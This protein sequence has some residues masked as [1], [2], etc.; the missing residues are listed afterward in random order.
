MTNIQNDLDNLTSHITDAQSKQ[1]L[2]ATITV[3]LRDLGHSPEL[4]ERTLDAFFN[5]T[6]H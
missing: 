4:V 2:R 3:G 1:M 6:V 5:E